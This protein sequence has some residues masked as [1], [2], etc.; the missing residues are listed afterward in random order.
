[1]ESSQESHSKDELS[2]FSHVT[3]ADMDPIMGPKEVYDKDTSP[4]KVNLLIGSYVDGEGKSY[5]F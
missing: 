4:L 1:M 3:M 2:I 5:V